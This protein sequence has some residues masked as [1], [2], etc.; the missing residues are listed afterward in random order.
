[1]QVE[2]AS[3]RLQPFILPRS[4]ELV[5]DRLEQSTTNSVSDTA[6]PSASVILIKGP[7]RSGKST[8]ARTLLNRLVTRYR[9][10]AFLECDVGQSEFTPAGMVSLHVLDTPAFG[11]PF[12][13]VAKKPI[14]AHWTGAATARTDPAHYLACVA[15]CVQTYLVDIQHS[16]EDDEVQGEEDDRI[17]DVVPLVVNTHGWNKG[18]GAD[19][20]LKIQEMVSAT[21]IVDFEPEPTDPASS[22]V[23]LHT[24]S[25]VDSSL[26]ANYT[27]SDFRV[28]NIMSYFYGTGDG[29]WDT[30]LP[31]CAVP[32]W[33]V[34][35][36]A[37]DAVVL[38]CPGGEDVPSFELAT[39]LNGGIVALVSAEPGALDIPDT[40]SS[41]NAPPLLPYKQATASPNPLLS[42]CIGLG[43]VR[44]ASA[45]S[46]HLLTPVS[47]ADLAQCRVLVKGELELPVVGWL[48]HHAVDGRIAGIP[49]DGVP[50]LQ[51]DAGD[52][53][54]ATRR[55]VRR[56]LM[57]WGQR[58]A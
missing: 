54:G 58:A 7:K 33:E 1:V 5:L 25:P 53:V 15:A 46:I 18:L 10:V 21:D 17:A 42:R 8:L 9:R 13:H 30:S 19:L 38:A 43:L 27:A 49:R 3:R 40:E 35:P 45:D 26:N 48:D 37:L 51:W 6:M 32:P 50:Y 36:E 52:G 28:L 41:T 34:G 57:R 55:K 16:F 4:W 39:A 23:R 12:T 22:T 47:P 14:V 24:V 44:Y 56:N 29:R 2:R 11:P 31:L 20:T